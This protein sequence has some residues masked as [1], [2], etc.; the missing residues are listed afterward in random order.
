MLTSYWPLSADVWFPSLFPE[1]GRASCPGPYAS[2]SDSKLAPWKCTPIRFQL[3]R[4]K[5]LELPPSAPQFRHSLA[6][7]FRN[8]YSHTLLESLPC[9][10]S[11]IRRKQFRNWNFLLV[12]PPKIAVEISFLGWKYLGPNTLHQLS[13]CHAGGVSMGVHNNIGAHSSLV[14]GHIFLRDN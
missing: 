2:A 6:S 10:R 11:L 1:H 13:N 7:P 9:L 5:S 3:P 8:N 12:H 4:T 14:E